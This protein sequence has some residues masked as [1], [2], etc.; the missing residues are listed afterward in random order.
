MTYEEMLKAMTPEMHRALRTAVELG[1]WPNGEKLSEEQRGICLR[2]VI[3]YDQQNLPEAERTGYI[4]RTR[5]DGSQ[6]GR[7]PLEPDVLK[8]ITDN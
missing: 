5:P 1:K 7:D 3:A 6:H 2:A 8:I 4:D